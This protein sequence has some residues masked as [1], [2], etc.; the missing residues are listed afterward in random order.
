MLLYTGSSALFGVRGFFPSGIGD[1]ALSMVNTH[2]DLKSKCPSCSCGIFD[3][4]YPSWLCDLQASRTTPH[5]VIA[6]MRSQ[7]CLHRSTDSGVR[8][9]A[10]QAFLRLL[11]AGFQASC[12]ARLLGAAR[13]RLHASSLI[14]SEIRQRFVSSNRGS[15]PPNS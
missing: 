6:H 9:Q 11:G 10:A 13:A 14:S 2:V 15:V 12:P 3:R 1:I 5:V 8:G 7:I 4:K